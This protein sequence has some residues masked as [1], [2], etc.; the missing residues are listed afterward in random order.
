MFKVIVADDE[1]R[2]VRLIGALIDWPALDLE[3]V[4]TAYN[5]IQALEQVQLHSPHILITDI[6]MPGCDGLELIS[7]AKALQP[8]LEIIIISGYAHFP[9]AQ[10]AMKHG[11]S[12]YLLKPINKNDLMQTLEKL[13]HKIQERQTLED[14]VRQLIAKDQTSKNRMRRQL[15]DHLLAGNVITEDILKEQYNFTIT[16]DGLQAFCLQLDYKTLSDEAIAVIFEKASNIFNANLQRICG[17]LVLN[18]GQQCLYGLLNFPM[19]NKGDVKRILRDCLNQMVSQKA[20]LGGVEFTIA[21]GFATKEVDQLSDSLRNAI[22]ISMERIVTKTERLLDVLPSETELHDEHLMERYARQ[23]TSALETF[24]HQEA[25]L[26][27]Q[28]LQ[29]FALHCN[30]IR[31]LEVLELIHSASTVFVMQANLKNQGEVLAEFKRQCQGCGSI[32]SLFS[33]LEQLQRTIM[34]SQESQRENEALRP[35]RLAKQYMQTHYN[36][37]ITLEQVSDIVGLSPTYFSTLFKKETGEGFAKYLISIRVERAKVLLRES[38]LSVSAI[39]K[40]VGYNDIKHFNQT[41][42]KVCQVKPSIYRKLYG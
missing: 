10:T 28:F 36:E 37:P 8:E 3:I 19:K 26:A 35:I 16:A 23:I 27:A 15:A 29:D 33:A 24:D 4:S 6:R 12:D 11:V 22:S 40:E 14:D 41:F 1:D 18:P 25:I 30:H 2:I 9:Y 39:C 32:Q 21:L 17:D 7:R 42:E 38:N 34:E 20:I 31:G 5:G 13:K